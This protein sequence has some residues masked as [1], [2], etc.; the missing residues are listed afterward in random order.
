MNYRFFFLIFTC[1]FYICCQK[2]SVSDSESIQLYLD[3]PEGKDTLLVN[4]NVSL[5]IF[6]AMTVGNNSYLYFSEYLILPNTNGQARMRLYLFRDKNIPRDVFFKST[7]SL[8]YETRTNPIENSSVYFEYSKNAASTYASYWKPQP[9]G[10]F[11]YFKN[12]RPLPD[13]S[14][15][16]ETHRVE[17]E[18]NCEVF[19][20]N[21]KAFSMK[22]KGSIKVNFDK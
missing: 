18:F 22:G 20:P 6:E 15:N 2:N 9:S 21:G 8:L 17:I 4:K 7:G 5:N 12:I 16:I 10:S 11:F 13:E 19:D 1:C 14:T 3:G